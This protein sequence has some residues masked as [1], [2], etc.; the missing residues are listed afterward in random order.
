MD[1]NQG[2]EEVDDVDSDIGDEGHNRKK[3][4]TTNIFRKYGHQLDFDTYFKSLCEQVSGFQPNATR[5]KRSKSG[6]IY[7]R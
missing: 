3:S 1:R 2:D 7:D 5:I 6:T 4:E